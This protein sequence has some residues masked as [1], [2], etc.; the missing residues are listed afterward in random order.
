MRTITRFA[1]LPK[2]IEGKW[3]W[4]RNYKVEQVWYYT[5]WDSDF[6]E[7]ITVNRKLR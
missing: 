5:G 3:I 7:W 1:L 4:L 2:K 6:F